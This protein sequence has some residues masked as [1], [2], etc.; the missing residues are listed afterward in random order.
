MNSF[1]RELRQYRHI[2]P[3]QTISTLRGQA[4]SGDLKAARKGLETASN[5]KQSNKDKMTNAHRGTRYMA[6]QYGDVDYK[7]QVGTYLKQ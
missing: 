7:T 5:K 6:K 4:L 1:I 2:L 3:K